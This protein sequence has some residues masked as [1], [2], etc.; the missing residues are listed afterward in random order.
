MASTHWILF[1]FD[2]VGQ[3]LV[4]KYKYRYRTKKT[5]LITGTC[6]LGASWERKWLA[7]T[8]IMFADD[9]WLK[10]ELKIKLS[11]KAKNYRF[12]TIQEKAELL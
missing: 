12:M 4:K 5:I 6:L 3:I 8:G 9:G 11:V 2:P 7:Y 10:H 1:P